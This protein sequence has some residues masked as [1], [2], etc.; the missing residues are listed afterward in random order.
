M[1]WKHLAGKKAI[2]MKSEKLENDRLGKGGGG[3]G[4]EGEEGYEGVE[5]EEEWKSPAKED[6]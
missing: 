3:G 6:N 5:E 2:T 4:D 1:V